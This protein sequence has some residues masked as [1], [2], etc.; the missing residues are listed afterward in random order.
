MNF[1][2]SCKDITVDSITNKTFD[3]A[4]KD[5]DPLLPQN[6][7]LTEA[8]KTSQNDT[9]TIL[10]EEKDPVQND[11][12]VNRRKATMQ[13][14]MTDQNLS[15]EQQ[16]E[17]SILPHDSTISLPENYQNLTAINGDPNKLLRS[18]YTIFNSTCLENVCTD[19][20]L[21]GEIPILLKGPNNK[22]SP[23]GH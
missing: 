12:L 4:E 22:S 10:I 13:N 5:A 18:I 9:I 6:T 3:I 7:L 14:A 15:E 21:L 20:K 1:A 23:F 8:H 11:T 19:E 16:N 2:N 17:N